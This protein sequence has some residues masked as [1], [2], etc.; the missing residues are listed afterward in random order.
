MR[1]CMCVAVWLWQIFSF[2]SSQICEK[3]TRRKNLERNDGK[4]ISLPL[5][6]SYFT[7]PTSEAAGKP[8]QQQH[9]HATP[10]AHSDNLLR[11]KVT[12][13]PAP[14]PATSLC[15][16]MSMSL[17]LALWPLFYAADIR[18]NNGNEMQAGWQQEQA[19]AARARAWAWP[20]SVTFSR[21]RI[22][23]NGSASAFALKPC[24]LLLAPYKAPG[25]C[26]RFKAIPCFAQL[27][28]VYVVI[29]FNPTYSATHWLS[30]VKN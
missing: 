17:S 28:L 30:Y 29:I 12:T 11:V 19:S 10:S 1:V 21:K 24:Q 25:H 8:W 5:Q 3:W 27:A 14:T 2:T 15:L 23:S 4:R 16:S 13:Q 26:L 20:S 18:T 22:Y 6:C 7:L 9:T